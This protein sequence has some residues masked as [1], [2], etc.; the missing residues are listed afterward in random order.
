MSNGPQRRLVMV[1]VAASFLGGA[2]ANLFLG[3][4][5]QAHSADPPK[6]TYKVISANRFILKDS[7]GRTRAALTSDKKTNRPQ[8][9]FL[10]EEGTLRM[11][12]SLG[13]TGN[14]TVSLMS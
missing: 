10:D 4:A 7:Q 3:G 1:C 2:L 14:P 13:K 8:L 5:K 9:M 12:M 11:I 6:S